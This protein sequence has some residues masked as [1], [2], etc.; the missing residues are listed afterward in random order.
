[1]KF[2]LSDKNQHKYNSF[3]L[4]IYDSILLTQKSKQENLL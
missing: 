3:N 1:M 4:T 2:S